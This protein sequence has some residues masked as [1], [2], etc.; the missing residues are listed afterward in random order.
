LPGLPLCQGGR[1]PAPVPHPRRVDRPSAGRQA[2]S[3]VGARRAPPTNDRSADLE[4]KP[5]GARP[6]NPMNPTCRTRSPSDS[7]TDD[8]TSLRHLAHADPGRRTPPD[9]EKRK[10]VGRFPLRCSCCPSGGPRHRLIQPRPPHGGSG[11]NL[12]GPCVGGASPTQHYGRPGSRFPR[13]Q[14]G[15]GRGP[16][17]T[18]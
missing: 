12:G 11:A 9:T 18:A 7:T 16:N 17:V 2:Q 1:V 3:R 13:T 10:P 14:V 4:A 15:R 5:S 6:S 8:G